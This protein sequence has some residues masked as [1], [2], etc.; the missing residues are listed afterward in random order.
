MKRFNG[1]YRDAFGN[2]VARHFDKFCEIANPLT[3]DP[4]ED[5][6]KVA[7]KP[8]HWA[9]M[10]MLLDSKFGKHCLMRGTSFSL[11]MPKEFHGQMK[12]QRKHIT[13]GFPDAKNRPPIDIEFHHL[14][15]D[16][17][18]KLDAWLKK[19]LGF[20]ELRKELWHR[21]DRLLDWDREKQWTGDCWRLMPSAGVGCNTPGQVHRIWPELLPFLPPEARH[22]VCNASVKS[23]LPEVIKDY[24]TPEQ[25]MCIERPR[26]EDGEECSDEEW[27][28]E[29]RKFAALSHILTQMSLMK[30]VP[31]VQGYPSVHV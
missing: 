26:N 12:H 22:V 5:V 3:F 13:F 2:A 6:Y 7:F 29:K 18:E 9:A 20:K 15:P 31:H 30:E 17:Q 21:C 10:N 16:V 23:K 14:H 27:D 4:L 1:E 8:K 24:G 28:H 11:Y 19:A 25:F